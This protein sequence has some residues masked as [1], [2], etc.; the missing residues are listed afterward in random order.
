MEF[1]GVL[2]WNVWCAVGRREIM[3]G[4]IEHAKPH[5]RRFGL[6]LQNFTK[7]AFI[8]YV[9]TSIPILPEADEGVSLK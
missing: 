6:T 3:S 2:I 4:S 1:C 9:E 5:R 7:L 8:R